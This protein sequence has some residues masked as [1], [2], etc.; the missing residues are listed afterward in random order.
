MNQ[1]QIVSKKETEIE[2]TTNKE[3]K[4]QDS[5]ISRKIY[6]MMT[7]SFQLWLIYLM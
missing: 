7:R 1:N 3:E 6:I 5:S 2:Q 4:N